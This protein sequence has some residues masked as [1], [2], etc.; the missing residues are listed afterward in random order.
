MHFGSSCEIIFKLRNLKL[1][2]EIHKSNILLCENAD[3][4]PTQVN[5]LQRVLQNWQE[6]KF[7]GGLELEVLSLGLCLLGQ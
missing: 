5:H 7:G 6:K 4:G 3:H 1:G 2:H